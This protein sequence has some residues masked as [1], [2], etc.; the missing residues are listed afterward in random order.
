[1]RLVRWALIYSL[2]FAVVLSVRVCLWMFKYQT[3]RQYLVRPCPDDPQANRKITVRRI[4]HAVARVARVI[5]DASC[6]TQSIS[7]QTML[8]WMGIP[9]TISM[10]VK[11]G[12]DSDLKVHAW[13]M[14]NEMVV[15]EGDE[16]TLQAFH[17]ILDLPPPSRSAQT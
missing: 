11:M 6:L 4:T 12:D 9:S 14:W 5:P 15:L 3:I 10:G 2:S 7:C 16:G 8:S 17:K 13:L 1:M